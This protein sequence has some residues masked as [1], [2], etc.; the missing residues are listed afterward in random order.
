MAKKRSEIV[1]D[2]T[3]KTVSRIYSHVPVTKTL[4]QTSDK[5]STG[6]FFPT[7]AVRIPVVEWAP[8]C[9]KAI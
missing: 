4:V 7:S 3:V 8:G 2:Q 5:Q 1:P 9:W 6:V